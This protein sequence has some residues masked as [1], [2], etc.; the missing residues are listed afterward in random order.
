MLRKQIKAPVPQYLYTPY[1]ALLFAL[2]LPIC[3]LSQYKIQMNYLHFALII[4]INFV[5]VM[6]GNI[7]MSGLKTFTKIIKIAAYFF[8]IIYTCAIIY[9][10]TQYGWSIS[11]S[12]MLVTSVMLITQAISTN[13]DP[14][15]INKWNISVF[16][17]CTILVSVNILINGFKYCK[18]ITP[19]II[20]TT[21]LL[22]IFVVF[23]SLHKALLFVFLGVLNYPLINLEFILLKTLMVIVFLAYM[24]G[25][26]NTINIHNNSTVFFIPNYDLKSM[27]SLILTTTIASTSLTIIHNLTILNMMYFIIITILVCCYTV[28]KFLKRI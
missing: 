5:L 14:I 3:V 26:A 27:I 28:L 16:D 20:L 22:F 4:S 2:G 25:Y 1:P 21:L 8:S 13:F 17:I 19:Y 23:I 15:L 7:V 9:I 10:L 24:H 11:K 12:T 6:L 18:S